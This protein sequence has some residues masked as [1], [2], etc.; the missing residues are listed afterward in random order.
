MSGLVK[1]L[2]GMG[3]PLLDIIADVDQ[4]VLDKYH[5]CTKAESFAMDVMACMHSCAEASL[6]DRPSID[7]SVSGAL[8]V[9]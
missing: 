2:L 8:L 1:S 9:N 5:V 4:A 6:F 3:N 7:R